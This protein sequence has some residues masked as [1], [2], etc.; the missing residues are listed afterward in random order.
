LALERPY[1]Y[2]ADLS[3]SLSNLAVKFAGVGL[4]EEAIRHAR[5]SVEIRR[6]LA[7]GDRGAHLPDLARTLS[8][9]TA[10]LVDAGHSENSLAVG[11]EAVDIFRKLAAEDSGVYLPPLVAALSNLITGLALVGQREESLELA[12]EAVDIR[13]RLAKSDPEAHLPGLAL[14][15][16]N[17]AIRMADLDRD[18][19]IESAWREAEVGLGC[20]VADLRTLR[21][22]WEWVQTPSIEDECAYLRAHPELLRQGSE[23]LLI[24]VMRHI[25]H[26]EARRFLAIVDMARRRGISAA[27]PGLAGAGADLPASRPRR[28]WAS[29]G[30]R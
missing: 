5:E 27:Y 26:Q 29:G 4:V 12:R 28:F 16:T 7:N 13:W 6:Q 30:Q 22:G 9:L 11:R 19:E 23:D 18:T 10:C 20:A 25:G 15:V 17:L 1:E 3:W 14:S 2:R 21:A 24:H 8:E